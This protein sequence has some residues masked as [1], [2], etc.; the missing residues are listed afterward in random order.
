[1]A[2]TYT[3]PIMGAKIVHN[4]ND[5]VS[6]LSIYNTDASEEQNQGLGAIQVSGSGQLAAFPCQ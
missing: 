6:K 3:S 1:M 2:L 4:F 5:R